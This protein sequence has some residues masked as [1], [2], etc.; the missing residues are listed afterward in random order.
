VNVY[1]ESNFVLELVPL[2]A[3]VLNASREMRRRYDLSPQDSIVFASVVKHLE[4]SKPDRACLAS[5]NPGDFRVPAL[6][7]E[8]GRFRCKLISR[9]SDTVQY[10][11]SQLS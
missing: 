7:A 2:S 4:T 3:P 9:F 8:L 11:E 6:L 1:A 10:L 5:R